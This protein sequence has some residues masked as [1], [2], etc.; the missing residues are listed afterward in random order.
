MR[1]EDQ[2]RHLGKSKGLAALACA[3]QAG[4]SEGSMFLSFWIFERKYLL[5][6]LISALYRCL[7][8][9]ALK[10]GLFFGLSLGK[11]RTGRKDY[12]SLALQKDAS[13]SVR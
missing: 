1:Q 6:L 13:G 3:D 7:R 5:K 2:Q 8:M 9:G 11:Y 12:Y 4:I 10:I